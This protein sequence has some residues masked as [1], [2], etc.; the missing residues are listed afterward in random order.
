MIQNAEDHYYETANTLLEITK[1][2]YDKFASSEIEKRR[3]LVKLVLS[4]LTLK[5]KTIRYE[6]REPFN[7]IL[8][9]NHSQSWLRG[10]GSNLQP[11][12]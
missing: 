4:N 7:M 2:A 5:N 12:R 3:Q 10:Q 9:F 8:K 6:A 11:S 1:Q